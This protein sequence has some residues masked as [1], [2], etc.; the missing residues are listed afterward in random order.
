MSSDDQ[1]REQ[2][3][4]RRLR[5]E[6]ELRR[7][8]KKRQRT[9]AMLAPVVVGAGVLAV[10]TL[11]SGD[12]KPNQAGGLLSRPSSVAFETSEAEAARAAAAGG[13]TLESTLAPGHAHTT[14]KVSYRTNPPASG[15]HDPI[16]ARDGEYTTA[17]AAEKLVHSAEHGRVILWFSPTAS[18]AT[19]TRL[20]AIFNSDPRL[21]ILTPNPTGMKYAAAATAW[22]GDRL[23]SP[24]APEFGHI[25][26][27]PRMTDRAA[28]AVRAFIA[29][30]RNQ[31]P[32]RVNRP[33]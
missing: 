1:Q 30:Y 4:E 20:K 13:C 3:R 16:P 33:E 21:M 7:A 22:S 26:G 24:P 11:A 9:A 28:A 6:A 12:S 31:G 27:C 10:A 15:P 23:A 2:L 5:R 8:E 18:A 32:E 19:R 25:L 14:A 17:P 29:A